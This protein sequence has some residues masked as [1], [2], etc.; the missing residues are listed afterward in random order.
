MARLKG[1]QSGNGAAWLIII[2][3]VLILLYLLYE[4]YLK[5]NGLL[6]LGF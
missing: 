6:D 3:V 5:P 4:W 2:V 1:K